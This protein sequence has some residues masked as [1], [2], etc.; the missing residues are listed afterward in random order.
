MASGLLTREVGCVHYD[1][2]IYDVRRLQ[3]DG[4]RNV[5]EGGLNVKRNGRARNGAAVPRSMVAGVAGSPAS[6]R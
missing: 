5:T 4:W 3:N 6:T 1:I 2:L